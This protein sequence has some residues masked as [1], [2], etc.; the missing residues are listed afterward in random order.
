MCS[1]HQSGGAG[2]PYPDGLIGRPYGS[3]LGDLPGVDLIQ[4]GRNYYS[5]N[6]YHDSVSTAMNY[7]GA[8]PPFSVG[9]KK[10]KHSRR[11]RRKRSNN[12]RQ[13]GGFVGLT[14]TIGQDL[15]NMGRQIGHDTQ[16]VFHRLSGTQPG[17]NPMPWIQSY[18]SGKSG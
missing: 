15:V 9:G 4:G 7:T 1:L 8:N 12:R 6:N 10:R 16:T 13:K 11:R 5:P 2:L 3:E 14:N 17:A 18:T